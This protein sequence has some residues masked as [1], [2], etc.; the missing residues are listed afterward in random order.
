MNRKFWRFL[1]IAE[2]SGKC[3][4]RSKSSHYYEM[5][6]EN[7]LQLNLKKKK[8]GIPEAGVT[9]IDGISEVTLDLTFKFFIVCM[10]IESGISINFSK[11][12]N[13]RM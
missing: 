6:K 3:F 10:L 7:V 11:A 4:R 5:D 2:V 13:R 9:S 1:L 12:P 8:P